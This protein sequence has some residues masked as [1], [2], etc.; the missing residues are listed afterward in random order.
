MALLS[1]RCDLDKAK[2]S[3]PVFLLVLEKSI[4]FSRPP[5]SIEDAWEILIKRIKTYEVLMRDI[6]KFDENRPPGG[7]EGGIET[8]IMLHLFELSVRHLG[9]P[10]MLS[11]VGISFLVEEIF[12]DTIDLL[13]ISLLYYLWLPP[14]CHGRGIQELSGAE[15]F[16]RI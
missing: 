2:I 12:L 16:R 15:G 10:P 6:G 1:Y 13:N 9:T 3:I 4:K 14:I 8:T 7:I 5:I 11:I